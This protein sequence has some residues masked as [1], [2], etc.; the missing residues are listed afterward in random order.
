MHH[1][2]LLK[3]YSDIEKDIRSELNIINSTFSK[4]FPSGLERLNSQCSGLKAELY[5]FSDSLKD[6]QARDSVLR[7][8]IV[9]QVKAGKSSFINA[10]LFGGQDILPK[11]A[12]PMTAALTVVKHSDEPGVFRAEID[13]FS[14][15]DW[16]TLEEEA[17]RYIKALKDQEQGQESLRRHQA[18][19]IQRPFGNRENPEIRKIR[20][21]L[22]N[23]QAVLDDPIKKVAHE[24]IEMARQNDIEPAICNESPRIQASTLAELSKELVQYVGVGGRF[25]PLV[26]SSTLYLN[27]DQMKG[28]ELVDTPGLN[29]P[30]LSRGERT[31]NYLGKC[32]VLFL[33]SYTGQFLEGA[34]L[35]LFS[36][37]FPSAGVNHVALVGSKLDAVILQ[38]KNTAGGDLKA[39]ARGVFNKLNDAASNILGRTAQ[40]NPA[41]QNILTR[42]LPPRFTSAI[43]HSAALKM[44]QSKSL[45]ATEKHILN[46]LRKVF[47]LSESLLSNPATLREI[48]GIDRLGTTEF[49]KL[50]ADKQE[51]LRTRYA[52]MSASK[53]PELKRQ[54]QEMA[55]GLAAE[56]KS[57]D[58]D[59][60]ELNKG[61][62][63]LKSEQEQLTEDV[64]I[65][66]AEKVREVNKL[67]S[68]LRQSGSRVA[69][70]DEVSIQTRQES[71]TISTSKWWNPFSWGRRE[72][73]YEDVQFIHP[74]RIINDLREGVET[75]CGTAEN[76]MSDLFSAEALKKLGKEVS[77][78]ILPILIKGDELVDTEPYVRNVSRIVCDIVKMPQFQVDISAMRSQIIKQFK[79]E[80][81]DIEEFKLAF[82]EMQ[83]SCA[84]QIKAQLDTQMENFRDILENRAKD[85]S[86]SII[87]GIT[88]QIE[89]LSQD[90][91]TRDKLAQAYH[92]MLKT[93]NKY[94]A[95]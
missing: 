24:L 86:N 11:A 30:V 43:L 28:F 6:I 29:D 40:D 61:L 62:A 10:L 67:M 3:K 73:R 84:Q 76:K 68:H 74:A 57:L 47:P 48:A 37:T 12:T 35:S 18:H 19:K 15:E 91:E 46:R 58:N 17:E 54:I 71:Y 95:A 13:F 21:S 36:R 42:A 44:G 94:S 9:G 65:L 31:L 41:L 56:I 88:K 53:E 7:I 50:R 79:S 66:F 22:D 78:K 34:D 89:E 23:A 52:A 92:Q 81:S 69:R 33:L 49:D 82:S 80:T 39:A 64:R 60:D 93:L 14:E 85:F 2:D 45:D 5:R 59:P 25:T 4:P 8:G 77:A 1:D 83:E 26:K 27:I 38:D 32:D 75:F 72:T 51:I 70:K 55:E 16:R 90:V 87:E 20:H 63:Q